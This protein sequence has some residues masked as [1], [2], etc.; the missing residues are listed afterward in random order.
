MWTKCRRSWAA[1]SYAD[2]FFYLRE[3]VYATGSGRSCAPGTGS[4]RCK[5]E[6]KAWKTFWGK[7]H[8]NMT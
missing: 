8:G 5:M 6:P 3:F 7:Y 2:F 4:V 1:G